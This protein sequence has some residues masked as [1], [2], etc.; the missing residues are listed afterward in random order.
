MVGYTIVSC[1]SKQ[2]MK[3]DDRQETFNVFK[4]RE[5]LIIPIFIYPLY[6]ARNSQMEY[7]SP[8]VNY[9]QSPLSARENDTLDE[10]LIQTPVFNKFN[11]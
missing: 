3:V 7:I 4:T 1:A 9:F 8:I 10:A 5:S 11:S 6:D 2:S